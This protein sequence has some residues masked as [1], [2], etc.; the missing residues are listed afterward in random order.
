MHQLIENPQNNLRLFIDGQFAYGM[1]TSELPIKSMPSTLE[2]IC[3]KYGA[4]V[5][6]EKLLLLLC[7]SLGS[8]SIDES[9][10]CQVKWLLWSFQISALGFDLSVRR[11]RS[12]RCPSQWSAWCYIP[13]SR[14]IKSNSVSSSGLLEKLNPCWE[15]R[16]WNAKRPVDFK[17]WQKSDRAHWSRYC[18]S[19]LTKT[20]KKVPRFGDTS[21][22]PWQ[23][24]SQW[25]FRSRFFLI[26]VHDVGEFFVVKC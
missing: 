5:E 12:W 16:Y 3:S 20:F 14:S 10:F 19:I 7:K 4:S 9:K 23:K 18:K 26:K 21:F 2:Q 17:R 25:L 24:I 8:V 15:R 13:A 22:L 11:T 1:E 6:Y